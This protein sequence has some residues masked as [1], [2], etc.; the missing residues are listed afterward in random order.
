MNDFQTA[1]TFVTKQVYQPNGLT[2][3]NILEEKQNAKYGAGTFLL[4]S[5]SVRFRVAHKTPT[6]LGQFV[7]FWKKKMSIARISR[8]QL[9]PLLICLSSQRLKIRLSLASLYFQKNCC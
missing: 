7:A 6:K 4:S 9:K 3:S 2:V 5:K 8:S 1:L